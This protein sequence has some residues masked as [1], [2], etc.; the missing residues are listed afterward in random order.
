MLVSKDHIKNLIPQRE[1]IL[2]IDELVEQ[3]EHK[4]VTSFLV[5]PENMFMRDG[6]LQEGGLLENIA[7]SAAARAGYYYHQM[8][9]NPPLGFIGAISKVKIEGFPEA[10]DLLKTTIEMK[11]E[12]FN[13]TLIRGFVEVNGNIIADCEMKIV[14]DDNRKK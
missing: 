11:S 1:P 9:E 7:Q 12:V 2:M 6:K 13:I 3:D 8:N 4:T 5:T 10:N 14:I